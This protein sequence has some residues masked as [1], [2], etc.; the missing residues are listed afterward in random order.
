MAKQLPAKAPAKKESPA[1][2]AGRNVGP[3]PQLVAFD[4]AMKLFHQRDFAAAMPYFA[5]ASEGA[6]KEI[7]QTAQL[8]YRMCEQR[9]GKGQPAVKSPEDLYALGVAQI[10]QRQLA[11]A[12]K[13]LSKAIALAPKADHIL[14]AY[15]LCRGLQGDV[16][17]AA[18]YL[19]Q[20]I[21]V[22]PSNR[23]A[24]RNDSDF[25]ELLQHQ[26]IREI[27]HLEKAGG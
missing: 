6:T 16:A 23:S 10:N 26:P 27:L 7:A 12:E 5:E 20:A 19:Q 14:Y 13:S 21:D 18:Q 24:A 22:Q 17:Q 15:A 25:R 2:T 4:K 8:H 1:K 3:D 9:T 11:E